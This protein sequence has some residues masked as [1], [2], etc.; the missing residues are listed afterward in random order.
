MLNMIEQLCGEKHVY[1]SFDK[2]G[3][4]TLIMMEIQQLQQH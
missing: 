3:G 4:K 1:S 2:S